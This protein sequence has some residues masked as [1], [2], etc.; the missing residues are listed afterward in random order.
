[1]PASAAMFS[2]RIAV[3]KNRC[4][5]TRTRSQCR[6]CWVCLLSGRFLAATTHIVEPPL[7]LKGFLGGLQAGVVCTASGA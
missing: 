5:R 1:M 6:A 3:G 7:V 4:S 2:I